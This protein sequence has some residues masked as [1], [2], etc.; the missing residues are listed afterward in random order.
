MAPALGLKPAVREVATVRLKISM[1]S[2]NEGLIGLVNR[3]YAVLEAIKLDYSTRKEAGTYNRESDIRRYQEQLNQWGNEVVRRMTEIFPTELEHNLFRN[4]E[5]PLGSVPGDIAY[6]NLIKYFGCLIRGLAMIRQTSL[7][8]YTDLPIE[9]RL[10]IEDIDSFQKVRDINPAMVAAFLKSGFLN[11]SED[12]VQLALEQIINVSFHRKDWG[13]E[14]N[15]LCTAN[16]IVNGTRRIAAFLLKGPGIGKREMTIADC[17]KN[18]DQIVRL[19]T[20]PADLFVVQHVGPI[21][22]FL[23]RDVQGKVAELRAQ[24]RV[25]HFL[26]IDGQDTARLLHAYGKLQ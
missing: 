26:V 5:I 21:A 17:G 20:T 24:G 13:G 22:D 23:V 19:F 7:P 16:V 9:D 11:W 12:Q 6:Q 2:A 14:V 18:G 15:D 10:Y 8:E 3:G 4:P 25:A 1:A